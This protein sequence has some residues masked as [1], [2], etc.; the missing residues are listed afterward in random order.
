MCDTNQH[1]DVL[2]T[3]NTGDFIDICTDRG[4]IVLDG[5]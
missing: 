2:I 4:I 1:I 5:K 3:F